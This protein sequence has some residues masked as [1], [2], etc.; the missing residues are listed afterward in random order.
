MRL[1]TG[2][3]VG[4]IVHEVV[5]DCCSAQEFEESVRDAIWACGVG[6]LGRAEGRNHRLGGI[7]RGLYQ[8][9]G[10]SVVALSLWFLDV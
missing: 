6:V 1:F 4:D 7:S 8:S 5:A 3:A 2:D 9:C 10:T